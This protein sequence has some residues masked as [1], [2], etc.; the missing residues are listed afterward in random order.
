MPQHGPGEDSATDLELADRC[1][2]AAE[3]DRGSIT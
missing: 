2:V 1:F 3:I